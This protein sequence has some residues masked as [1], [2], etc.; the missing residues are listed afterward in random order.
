MKFDDDND[1]TTPDQTTR[2][3]HDEYSFTSYAVEQGGEALAHGKVK[4][5]NRTDAY[6]EVVVIENSVA[7]WVGDTHYFINSADTLMV[8]HDGNKGRINLYT[9]SE[10][11]Q[12][13]GNGSDGYMWVKI[14]GAE[15]GL[16][17]GDDVK[18]SMS[19]ADPEKLA[20]LVPLPRDKDGL[21]A[22]LTTV[23]GEVGQ[24]GELVISPNPVQL[25]EFYETS[26]GSRKRQFVIIKDADN[27]VYD[28]CEVV[29]I[30][31][32]MEGGNAEPSEP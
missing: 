14:E 32:A 18:D 12:K 30:T 28:L 25:Y 24:Q 19:Y 15:H 20:F 29:N 22:N 6:S 17:D 27:N 1:A 21:L 11:Q 31:F 5:V 10:C 26:G 23:N 4:V 9:D 13:V 7:G 8:D 16:L 2:V 3:A